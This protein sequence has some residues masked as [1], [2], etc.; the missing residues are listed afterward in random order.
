MSVTYAREQTL[1]V[2]DFRAVLANVSTGLKRPLDDTARLQAMLDNANFIVTARTEAGEIVGLAR[3]MTDFAWTCYCAE[4]AVHDAHQGKGIGTG[5]IRKCRELLG[6]QV[7]F[8]LT[9][10]PSAAS[11]YEHVGPH[12]GM[13]RVANA[14]WI[15][16]EKGA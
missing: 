13:A 12:L 4:L 14:F 3:C 7:S 16:R 15:N 9:S 11:F 10:V 8:N 1:S 5:L 2:S 6:P